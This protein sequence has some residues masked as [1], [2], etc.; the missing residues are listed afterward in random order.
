MPKSFIEKFLF[1]SVFQFK[2]KIIDK[3]GCEYKNVIPP[4]FTEF[5]F[6]LQ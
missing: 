3:I 1:T 4:S 6:Q 5:E 2:W